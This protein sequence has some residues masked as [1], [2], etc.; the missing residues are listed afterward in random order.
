MYL[1]YYVCYASIVFIP[2]KNYVIRIQLDVR[3][4]PNFIIIHSL[5][6]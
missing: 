3:M 5:I 6:L 1:T 2:K 4:P